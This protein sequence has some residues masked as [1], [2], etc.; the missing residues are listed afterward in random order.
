ML[1]K[2]IF[3]WPYWIFTVIFQ[4]ITNNAVGHFYM[5]KWLIFY[6]CLVP[7]SFLWVSV[8]SLKFSVQI[9]KGIMLKEGCIRL[10]FLLLLL[11]KEKETLTLN[12]IALTESIL[13]NQI[14]AVH[15]FLLWLLERIDKMD[16]QVFHSLKRQKGCLNKEN[17]SALP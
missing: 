1:F 16:A 10:L 17:D 2:H 3:L 7:Y 8:V 11:L 9:F 12:P 13:K 5:S 15:S 14:T 4:Y 6:F